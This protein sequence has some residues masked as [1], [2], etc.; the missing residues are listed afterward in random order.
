MNLSKITKRSRDGGMIEAI[1]HAQTRNERPI[2][3]II[4]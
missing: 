3:N 2:K 4:L 1:D